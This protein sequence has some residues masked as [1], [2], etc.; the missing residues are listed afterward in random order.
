MAS[1]PASGTPLP[2]SVVAFLKGFVVFAALVGFA[3]MFGVGIYQTWTAA[4]DHPPVFNEPF[5]YVATT[6]AALIGGIVAVGFGQKPPV[7]GPPQGPSIETSRS[8]LMRSQH[9]QIGLDPR[10]LAS[11]SITSLARLLLTAAANPK[12]WQKI[13]ASLYALIYFF[14]GLASVLT[15][16]VHPSE[17]PDLVKNLATTFLGLAIPVAAGFFGS[18]AE[19]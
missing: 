15:W 13:L 5:L 1:S 18:Q 19:R 16:V 6:I 8:T 2:P 9:G 11:L 12:L 4:A 10:I 3:S 17:A 14:W 7:P